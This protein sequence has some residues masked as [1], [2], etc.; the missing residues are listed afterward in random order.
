MASLN[1]DMKPQQI[2]KGIKSISYTYHPFPHA[3]LKGFISLLVLILF[4]YLSARYMGNLLYGLVVFSIGFLSLASF[5][6]PAKYHLDEKGVERI[7]PG[8]MRTSRAWTEIRRLEHSSNSLRLSPFS[9]RTFLDAFRAMELPLCGD[10]RLIE[11][12]IR[13]H[14]DSVKRKTEGIKHPSAHR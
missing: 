9:R 5:Y 2:E 14:I 4:A 8:M 10:R 6:F 13:Q 3:R 1:E 7:Y 12:F 11:A